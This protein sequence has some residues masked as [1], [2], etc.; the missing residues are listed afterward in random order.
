MYDKTYMK[1]SSFMIHDRIIH[2]VGILNST[3]KKKTHS[4]C[5]LYMN[6]ETLHSMHFFSQ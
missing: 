1:L 4:E 2:L 6:K 5:T 3:Q